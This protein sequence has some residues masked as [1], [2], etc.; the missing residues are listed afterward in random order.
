MDGDRAPLREI[1][2]LKS[3]FQALLL[4]AGEAHAVG[5]IRAKRLRQRRR[6]S[7]PLTFKWG[8]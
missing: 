8:R 5:V 6:K 4:L 2:E 7:C 3:R 1:V